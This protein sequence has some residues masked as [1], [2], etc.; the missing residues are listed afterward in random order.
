MPAFFLHALSSRVCLLM[1]RVASAR[2]QYRSYALAVSLASASQ[3]RSYTRAVR[4]DAACCVWLVI[5]QPSVNRDLGHHCSALLPRL[6]CGKGKV[7]ADRWSRLC[8]RRARTTASAL[9]GVQ[10]AGSC[11]QRHNTTSRDTQER[12]FGARPDKKAHHQNRFC[13]Q[14]GA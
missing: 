8:L 4:D 13:S 6:A 11:E 2:Y 5:S 1:Q 7:A 3:Q 10:S 9:S 14:S 12:S